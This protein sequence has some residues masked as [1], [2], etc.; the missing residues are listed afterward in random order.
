MVDPYVNDEF[1]VKPGLTLTLGLRWDPD[2]APSSVGGRG[3]A[4]V[5]GP[6]KRHLPAAPTGLVFP[7]D[8]AWTPRFAR[9][10]SISLSR[11]SA[12]PG[13][14][15]ICPTPHSTR[16]S[17]SSAA[18]CRTPTTTMSSISRRLRRH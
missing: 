1:R 3:A 8:Q 4:F 18:L 16:H 6:A 7:G 12:L 9:A 11:A 10:A 15:R 17:A 2:F 5:A 13:S 14:P